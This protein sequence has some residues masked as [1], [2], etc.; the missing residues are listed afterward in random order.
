MADT[1]FSDE[2]LLEQAS[3]NQ[4][5]MFFVG[6]AWAKQRDGSI[7][8]WADFVG[9]QFA[10]SWES[11]RGGGALAVARMAGLNMAS[12]A[13]SRLVGLEGD[14]A[15]AEAV[16]DG[17][18]PEWLE[19]TTLTR[20]DADRANERIFRRIAEHIGLELEARRDATGLH[21]T[22]KERSAAG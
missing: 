14:E 1:D 6:L 16:I 3:G 4:S 20:E 19:N 13:D 8:G 5:A 2:R 9:E 17:P 7:D 21:L 10:D 15:K 11:L 12:S 22:F 18:D